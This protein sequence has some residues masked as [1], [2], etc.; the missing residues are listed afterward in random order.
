MTLRT[1]NR[2]VVFHCYANKQWYG[3]R[4]IGFTVGYPVTWEM[5]YENCGLSCIWAIRA[6]YLTLWWFTFVVK[7]GH[8]KPA[9]INAIPQ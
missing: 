9:R 7:Y 6:W 2:F 3:K 4:H 1:S 8:L 5:H